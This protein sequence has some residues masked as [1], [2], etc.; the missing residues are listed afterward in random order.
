VNFAISPKNISVYFAFLYLPFHNFHMKV[1]HSFERLI[2]CYSGAFEDIFAQVG[3]NLISQISKSTNSRGRPGVGM[4]KFRIDRYIIMQQF[5]N[6]LVLL[7]SILTTV[8]PILTSITS[9]QSGL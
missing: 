9:V 4:L 3:E 5:L 7:F 8:S 1:G 6:L 2:S